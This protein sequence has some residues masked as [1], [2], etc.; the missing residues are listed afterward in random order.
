MRRIRAGV[1]PR[2]VKDAIDLPWCAPT[3]RRRGECNPSLSDAMN[4]S[5]P[6][7]HSSSTSRSDPPAVELS[8]APELKPGDIVVTEGGDR[9]RD[10]AKIAPAGSA[11][12]KVS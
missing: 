3:R 2:R 12:S 9:L 1:R 4:I 10:G 6:L 11:P 8:L 7:L 5:S